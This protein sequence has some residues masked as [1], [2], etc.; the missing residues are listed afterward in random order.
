M[1]GGTSIIKYGVVSL[2]HKHLSADQAQVVCL[3]MLRETAVEK[4]PSVRDGRNGK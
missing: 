1:V 4:V 2:Q 3:I